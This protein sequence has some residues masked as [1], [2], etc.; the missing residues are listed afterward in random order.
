[1]RLRVQR[2]HWCIGDLE[3]YTAWYDQAAGWEVAHHVPHPRLQAPSHPSRSDEPLV[4]IVRTDPE[5][6]KGITVFGGE[7]AIVIGHSGGP[8]I[9][10][11]WLEAEGA[12]LWILAPERELLVGSA[13][14]LCR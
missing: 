4:L 12:V 11:D 1:M 2:S 9:R 14:N 10:A 6:Q 8:E 13:L 5:P 3:H 7:G